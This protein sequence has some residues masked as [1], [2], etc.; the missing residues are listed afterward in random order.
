MFDKPTTPYVW[1]HQAYDNNY[2]NCGLTGYTGLD[3][4]TVGQL[5]VMPAWRAQVGQRGFYKAGL[6]VLEDGTLIASPV[7]ML[8]PRQKPPFSSGLVTES[9]P[10]RLH[11]STD[12]GRSWQPIE[13]SPLVGKEGS[14]TCLDNGV[15]LFTSESLDGVAWSDDRGVTWEHV[16]FDTPRSDPYQ[17]VFPVRAPIL[18]P[19]GDI[20]FVRSVGTMEGTAPDGHESP[21]SQAWLVTSTDGGHSW[22]ERQPIETWDD[23]FPLFAE[24]DFVRLQDGRLLSSSRFEWL[25]PLAGKPLPYP[26]GKMPNDHAAGHMVLV[27]SH[28]EGHSWSAPREFLQYSEVQ[29]QLTL[30]Q[31]GRLLCTY[32]NYHLPFGVG[33][34]LSSDAGKTWDFAHP[35]Q[36]AV[37]NGHAAGWATT[38]QLGDGTL[39][40]IYA[41][42]PYHI[43]P[44]ETGTSVCH[45]VRWL[46][47]PA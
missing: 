16:N 41:L 47:P 36:L 4:H 27:E 18:H 33:G 37:S 15:L 28:D 7:D 43:E 22:D 44:A 6:A 23:T 26:P 24:A 39:V 10:V 42:T 13:H 34:V 1:D 25:H 5:S 17:A 31:D 45:S 2:E 32:T 14:L 30:L 46:P 8:A 29:G 12:E 38:R 19:D 9:W 11:K 20:S 21:A 3:Y 35:L 40:T